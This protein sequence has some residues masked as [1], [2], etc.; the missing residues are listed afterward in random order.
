M[1]KEDRVCVGA[2]AGAFGVKGEARLK[3]FCSTPEDIATYGPLWLED[4]T[5][6]FMVTLTR[7]V[8]GGMGARLTGLATKEEIDALKG[9][10]LWA[11]R[12]RLPSLPDDEF[13][14][15]DLIGLPVF[16]AGGVQIGKVRAVQNFGAGDI[17]EIFAP[18]R[19]TTLMLPFT[20]AVVPTV[21]LKAGRIIADPPEELE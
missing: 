21:D 5:R 7:P 15:T 20:R 3:S 18:G 19:K 2:I 12:D 10:T 9:A 14:H 17:L 6:S 4:G 13:Y 1:T 16:D 8:T 11:D